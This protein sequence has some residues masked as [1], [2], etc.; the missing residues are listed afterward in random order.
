MILGDFKKIYG[1][2]WLFLWN[3][4]FLLKRTPCHWV[5]CEIFR[6]S[7]RLS[8][9]NQEKRSLQKILLLSSNPEPTKRISV[10][11]GLSFLTELVRANICGNPIYWWEKHGKTM[12][13]CRF[14]HQPQWNVLLLPR[15]GW[16]ERVWL[17]S[18]Q[19]CMTSWCPW[20]GLPAHYGTRW[21]LDFM[22][23]FCLQLLYSHVPTYTI[24]IE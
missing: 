1:K 19:W 13:L 10:G 8:H 12:V 4:G 22:P 6:G 21:L 18:W 5:S 24:I 2:P 9:T 23:L 20:W 11:L 7:C 14:S 16:S 3:V 15:V 17:D